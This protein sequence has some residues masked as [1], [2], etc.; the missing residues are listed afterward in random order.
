MPR[1]SARRWSSPIGRSASFARST[2]RPGRRAAAPRSFSA[3][4]RPRARRQRHGRV[5][6]PALDDPFAA[7]DAGNFGLPARPRLRR[8]GRR[9]PCRGV[10]REAGARLLRGR[11]GDPRRRHPYPCADS[12]R[13]ILPAGTAYQT[14][15]GMCGD[16][17]SSRHGQ[18]RADPAGVAVVD[19]DRRAAGLR[20][21]VGREAADVPAVA[22]RQQREDGDLRVLGGVQRAEERLERQRRI[23]Q[24]GSSYHSAWV[25]NEVAGRSSAIRSTAS[26]SESRRRW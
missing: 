19:E 2:I 17:D 4:R 21:Q 3:E 25:A 15:A 8:H 9:H 26:W 7:I 18:G 13:R 16:Y 10:E 24:S 6:M 20:V 11:Q 22:H 14:D 5:F 12:G 23:E 1:T